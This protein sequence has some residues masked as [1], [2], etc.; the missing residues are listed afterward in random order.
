MRL[1]GLRQVVAFWEAPCLLALRFCGKDNVLD[2]EVDISNG[3]TT[4]KTLNS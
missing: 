3:L 2:T 4:S 1:L